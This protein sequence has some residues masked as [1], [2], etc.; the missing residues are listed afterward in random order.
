MRKIVFIIL[1]IIVTAVVGVFV[2][3]EMSVPGINFVTDRIN[4]DV[5]NQVTIQR[6]YA[7]QVDHDAYEAALELISRVSEYTEEERFAAAIA[8][9]QPEFFPGFNLSVYRKNEEVR[10]L[11][12]IDQSLADNQKTERYSMGEVSFE[13]VVTQGDFTIDDIEVT[14]NE[15]TQNLPLTKIFTP[16]T[17]TVD[18]SNALMFE[19]VLSGDSGAVNMQFIYSIVADTF[20]TRTMLTEQYLEVT[21][22]ITRNEI[23]DVE[24]EYITEPYSNLEELDAQ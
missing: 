3:L 18:I 22:V 17:A 23:G 12:F 1:A 9:G 7:A 16:Q 2:F 8:S 11:G 19:I 15:G 20:M 5:I 6:L 21:A 13:A 4:D 10:L 14:P 24:V